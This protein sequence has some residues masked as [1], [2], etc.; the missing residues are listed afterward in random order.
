MSTIVVI[1]LLV[2]RDA[3]ASTLMTSLI[4]PDRLTSTAAVAMLNTF[5]VGFLAILGLVVVTSDAFSSISQAGWADVLVVKPY[6]RWKLYAYRF[7][8]IQGI[9]TVYLT[10]LAIIVYFMTGLWWGMWLHGL[11]LSGIVY[12]L[13]FSFLLAISSIAGVWT[14]SKFRTLLL[15]LLIWA[16]VG[17]VQRGRDIIRTN[18]SWG[19][20]SQEQ[21]TT[22]TLELAWVVIPK[23]AAVHQMASSLIIPSEPAQQQTGS[24]RS[25]LDEP[26]YLANAI[27][28]SA[29]FELVAILMALRIYCRRDM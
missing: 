14:G 6:H 17:G 19:N 27:L 7:L 10:L 11:L 24:N 16:V 3:A 13:T 1:M 21:I 28:S 20:T 8:A 25:S 9:A 15:T 23:T 29:I 26:S 2:G 12:S 22:Y 18:P 4:P 5:F